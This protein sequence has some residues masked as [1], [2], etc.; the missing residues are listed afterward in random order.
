[1]KHIKIHPLPSFF[2][3]LLLCLHS[4]S[5]LLLLIIFAGNINRAIHVSVLH[6]PVLYLIIISCNIIC[7]LLFAI[8]TIILHKILHKFGNSILLVAITADS[9][10]ASLNLNTIHIWIVPELHSNSSIKY[11]VVPYSP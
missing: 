6:S 10:S 3:S 11:K 9:S 7:F 8:H 4:L 2:A 5:L 1:M